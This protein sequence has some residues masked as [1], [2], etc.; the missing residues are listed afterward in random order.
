MTSPD[1]RIDGQA[2]AANNRITDPLSTTEPEPALARKETTTRSSPL[3]RGSE[4][5]GGW[6]R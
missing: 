4:G 6:Q 2:D 5:S 1:F 3:D